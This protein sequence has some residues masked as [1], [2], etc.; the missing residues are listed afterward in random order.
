[1]HP[2]IT[3]A[4]LLACFAA[5]PAHAQA[6]APGSSGGGGVGPSVSPP[7]EP[8][9]T[10]PPGTPS[11]ETTGDRALRNAAGDSVTG[12]TDTLASPIPGDTMAPDAGVRK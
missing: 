7:A 2:S 5:V 6:P 3:A 12:K 4:I 10:T 9:G 1:M 8:Q 11:G